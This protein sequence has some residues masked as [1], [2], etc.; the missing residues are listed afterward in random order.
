MGPNPN[1]P[2]S[3]SCNRA[4]RYSG[5]FGVRETWVPLEISWKLSTQESFGP[6]TSPTE[7]LDI[8]DIDVA[9]RPNELKDFDGRNNGPPLEVAGRSQPRVAGRVIPSFHCCT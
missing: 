4:I 5:F 2:R 3:V 1:G 9:G 7:D 6:G 8:V